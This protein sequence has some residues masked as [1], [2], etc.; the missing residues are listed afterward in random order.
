MISKL[1]ES[2]KFPDREF[3]SSKREVEI[4]H[5]KIGGQD[6]AAYIFKSIQ[7]V[8]TWLPDIKVFNPI[9]EVKNKSSC[10][11]VL[12]KASDRILSRHLLMVGN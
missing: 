9:P 8:P 12:F 6:A 10:A 4:R 1:T 5:S 2:E 11:V 3:S 7:K